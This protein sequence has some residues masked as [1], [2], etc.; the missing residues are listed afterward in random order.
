MTELAGEADRMTELLGDDHDA[1]VLR[2]KLV[3]APEEFGG[4]EGVEMLL[5]LVDRRRAELQQQALALGLR[6]FEEQSKAFARRLKGYWNALHRTQ[7]RELGVSARGNLRLQPMKT[8]NS[9]KLVLD[10][11]GLC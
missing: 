4:P 8:S 10:S 2:Q 9:K 11:S 6:F 3:N 1:A 5:A 7:E